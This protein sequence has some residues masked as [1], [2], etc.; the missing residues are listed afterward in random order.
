MD[1]TSVA[2]PVPILAWQFASKF[3]SSSPSRVAVNETSSRIYTTSTVGRY[4]TSV[5]KD[6]RHQLLRAYDPKDGGPCDGWMRR[7]HNKSENVHMRAPFGSQMEER[8]DGQ[9][10]ALGTGRTIV[11]L[12]CPLT[13]NASITRVS[14]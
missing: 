6:H 8:G 1:R 4:V 3:G 7:V 10:A 5:E 9:T 12:T 13:D 14:E 2:A 11:E